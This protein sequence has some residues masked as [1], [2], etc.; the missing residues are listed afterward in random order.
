MELTREAQVI[1]VIVRFYDNVLR[2]KLVCWAS[3]QHLDYG[4]WSTRYFGGF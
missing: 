3:P 2:W 1:T 4:L